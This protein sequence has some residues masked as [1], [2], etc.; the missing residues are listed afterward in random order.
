MSC[1]NTGNYSC[2]CYKGYT[3]LPGPGPGICRD[4]NECELHTDGCSH[5]C[6]NTEGSFVCRCP[7][8]LLLSEDRKTCVTSR[9]RHR[10]SPAAPSQMLSSSI[11]KAESRGTRDDRNFCQFKCLNGGTCK[12]GHCHC[13]TGLIGTVCENGKCAML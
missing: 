7:A 4:L 9:Q 11:H 13:P 2:S 5:L 12:Q 1:L 6:S 3:L 10:K 8:P